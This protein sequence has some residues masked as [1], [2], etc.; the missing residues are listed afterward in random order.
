MVEM[1][2]CSDAAICLP[3]L[4]LALLF[5]TILEASRL[6]KVGLKEAVSRC[7][8]TIK[9]VHPTKKEVQ[10]RMYA[11]AEIGWIKWPH[12]P[13]TSFWISLRSLGGPPCSAEICC[14]REAPLFAA[15]RSLRRRAFCCA[16][17]SSAGAGEAGESAMS[18]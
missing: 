2:A 10:A 8:C 9:V 11:P 16:G 4:G 17:D 5:Q 1:R 14:S 18:A 15:R 13:G 3:H 6:G 12:I 7:A